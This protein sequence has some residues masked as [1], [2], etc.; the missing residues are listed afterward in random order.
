[1]YAAK[2]FRENRLPV[3]RDFIRENAFAAVVTNGA[4]GM[5]ASHVPLILDATH[6]THGRL[7]GHVARANPQWRDLAEADE[8]LAIFQGPQAYISPTWYPSKQENGKVVPTWDYLAVHAYGPARVFE[9][10]ASLRELLETLTDQH[11]ASQAAPW[12]VSDAPEDYVE[13]AMRAIVGFELSLSRIEGIWKM[14][15]NRSREDR[16]GAAIGLRQSG[17]H[18]VADL[19]ERLGGDE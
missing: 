3:L 15:Q 11:E 5:L 6:G 10:A 13:D 9:D 19:I 7:L 4:D 17:E 12:S 18:E 16:T 1:M 14:S 2:S 8:V